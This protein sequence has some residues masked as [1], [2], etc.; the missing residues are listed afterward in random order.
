MDYC[1]V[2]Q[3]FSAIEKI[4]SR[5]E[6]TSLLAQLFEKASGQEINIISNIS[7]GQLH[8][9]Y[10]NVHFNMA[11]KTV[12]K[13]VVQLL[14]ISSQQVTQGVKQLGDIGI[15]IE[16]HT[17]QSSS[18]PLSLTT[19]YET[20]C[21]LATV[22]GTGS[23]E[24]KVHMLYRLLEQLDPLSAKYVL[25][26]VVGKLRLGF[27]DMTIIDALSWM[28]CGDKSARS[29][30]ENA[31]NICA[32]IGYIAQE[33]KQH[34]LD[35]LTHQA[36]NVG[37]PIRPAAAE[38]L[39]TA[40]LIFD[41]IGTCVAQPKLDGFRLQ[42]HINKASPQPAVH[43]FSRNLLDMSDMFPDLVTHLLSLPVTTLIVEGEAISFDANTGN[44]LPFQET[45]RRKRK[46]DIA[47]AQEDFPLKLFLF[48]I[49][50]LNGESMLDHTHEQRRTELVKLIQH[51]HVESVELIPEWPIDAAGILESHFY[52]SIAAGLEGLVVKRPDAIYKPGKRN[53]NW[54]KLKRHQ[55]GHLHDT[56]DV[57]VLGYY[58]G[59]GKRTSF[60]IGAFLVG[61]YDQECDNFQTI[62]KIG[63]GLSDTQWCELK[64]VCDQVAT[65]SQP[66]NVVCAKALMP[67]VWVTPH[68]VY[69]AY[70]DEIT[71]SPLHAAGKKE[72][73]LGYALRFPRALHFRPDK[74]PYQ[75]TTV[76][77]IVSLYNHQ[78]IKSAVSV[79]E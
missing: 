21:A 73:S 40:S 29:V 9:P 71:V 57:V 53:F 58:A 41:K 22:S 8:P 45:V 55:Q 49:L 70:A 16:Q 61:V 65:S 1:D 12:V 4:S 33:I 60:G 67:D 72:D 20:L 50:Y 44:F 15:F 62:A 14:G 48:D 78:S 63:T 25:R 75:A 10:M 36:I 66:T 47:K 42:V 56:L 3:L 23:Q 74:G 77:E 24:S 32:D 64:K 43:F 68:I 31:Y 27:S 39:A 19:V 11:E 13:A 76:K 54:I 46:H 17:W 38:R 18:T 37:I 5:L 69:T 34:G 6:M 79:Q 2:A 35:I 26:I 7:L 52:E 30:I 28:V 59:K 51:T